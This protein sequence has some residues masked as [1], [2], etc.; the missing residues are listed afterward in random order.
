[1]FFGLNPCEELHNAYACSQYLTLGSKEM[2]RRF[3]FQTI[4]NNPSPPV[5]AQFGQVRSGPTPAAPEFEMN[6]DDF[7]DFGHSFSM[8]N[9]MAG[10]SNA[11]A[12]EADDGENLECFRLT[13]SQRLPENDGVLEVTCIEEKLSVSL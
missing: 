6:E 10:N 7:E 4:R 9:V 8:T 5:L 11:G 1:M 12:D 2:L 3:F 13:M